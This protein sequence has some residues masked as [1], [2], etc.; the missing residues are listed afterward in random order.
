MFLYCFCS[1]P[2]PFFSSEIDELEKRLGSLEKNTAL[3]LSGKEKIAGGYKTLPPELGK[4]ACEAYPISSDRKS[5]KE[6][7][8]EL[9]FFEN[10]KNSEKLSADQSSRLSSL[11]KT[12]FNL[13]PGVDCNNLK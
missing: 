7:K 6:F 5:I 13:K 4:I 10:K 1:Q 8:K 11:R 12:I 3:F 2:T 9:K